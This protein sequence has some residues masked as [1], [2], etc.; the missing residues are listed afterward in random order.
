MAAAAEEDAWQRRVADAMAAIRPLKSINVSWN[1]KKKRSNG[2]REGGR[3]SR[4]GK[5]IRRW[6]AGGG[7]HLEPYHTLRRWSMKSS[8]L[9]F[10]A[11]SVGP[12]GGVLWG[13][14]RQQCSSI[15]WSGLVCY[16]VVTVGLE[17]RGGE[18]RHSRHLSPAWQFA[19][20]PTRVDVDLTS[21]RPAS[22]PL[23]PLPWR[24][25]TPPCPARQPPRPTA[26]LPHS[27]SS[28]SSDEKL[29]VEE[30]CRSGALRGIHRP[31]QSSRLS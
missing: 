13:A 2:G 29:S 25:L 8:N 31:R 20:R 4:G 21:G 18:V 3:R 28:W 9:Y 19:F 22:G 12:R 5:K 7:G 23:A 27:P 26:S 1:D 30:P 24:R 11:W 15:S 14:R 17:G 10:M 16:Q 6:M